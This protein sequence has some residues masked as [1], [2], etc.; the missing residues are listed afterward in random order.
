MHA[1]R[2]EKGSSDGSKES[3]TADSLLA[4]GADNGGLAVVTRARSLA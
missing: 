1:L 4:S 2:L 3:K